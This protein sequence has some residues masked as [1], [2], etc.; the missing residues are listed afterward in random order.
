MSS[1]SIEFMSFSQKCEANPVN[2]GIVILSL[3]IVTKGLGSDF[4]Y[5]YMVE[6]SALR[7]LFMEEDSII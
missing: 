2:F 4:S 1:F 6:P 7:E 3:I 5:I